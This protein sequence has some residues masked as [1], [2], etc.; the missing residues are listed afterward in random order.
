MSIA[1]AVADLALPFTLSRE[2]ESSRLLVLSATLIFIFG[3]LFLFL[4]FGFVPFDVQ[5][6]FHLRKDE[7]KKIHEARK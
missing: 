1:D 5:T 7:K 4:S 3:F 2:S 6:F